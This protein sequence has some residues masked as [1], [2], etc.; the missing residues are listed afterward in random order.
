MKGQLRW[1]ALE[2]GTTGEG[3]SVAYPSPMHRHQA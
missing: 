1:A 2:S 3:S